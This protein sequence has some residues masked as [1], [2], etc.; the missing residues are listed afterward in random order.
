MVL[1]AL[2][3]GAFVIALDPIADGDIFWHLAAGR[4]MVHRH[5]LLDTDTFT[6]S[7]S[8]RPWL[9]LHWLFQLGSFA[10][11]RTAGL[12]GLVIA[13]AFLVATGSVILARAVSRSATPSKVVASAGSNGSF[14]VA[15][16]AIGLLGA[17]FLSRHLLLVRPVIVTLVMLALFL[18][19]LEASRSGTLRALRWLPVLQVLW[20]N[21]QGLAVLGPVLI[22]IYLVSAVAGARGDH[23]HDLLMSRSHRGWNW[24]WSW[25]RRW[26][27]P[28]PWPWP[29]REEGALSR[30]ALAITLGLCCLGLLANPHGLRAVGLSGTLFLRLLPRAG[31]V[32]SSQ[33]AENVPPWLLQRSAPAGIS[34]FAW[35]LGAFGACLV[36]SRERLTLSRLL[37]VMVF[38]GLALVAN[39]N[40]LLFYWI[41]TPIAA[42]AIAPRIR[43]ALGHLVG[44]L[45]LGRSL[46]GRRWIDRRSGRPDDASWTRRV[47]LVPALAVL[48]G[49]IALAGVAHSRESSIASPVP[50]HFPV[51]SS[52][53]L[54]RQGASGSIFAPDHHGGYLELNAPAMRPFIDTR[55]ILHTADEYLAYLQAVAD[56]VKFD[57]L[58]AAQDFRYV[59][60]TTMYPDRY[61]GLAQHL[62]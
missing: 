24:S 39:R 5:A 7:G 41:A 55:L 34:H 12:A 31:N 59:V 29:F 60:L 6:S 56:P 16:C 20:V 47:E 43:S 2:F 27:W 61:L 11:N 1:A 3:L 62:A 17:L 18:A 45:L 26:R 58:A 51:E 33:I 48:L 23:R 25:G 15:C 46:L 14:E 57:A 35:Y 50:F 53:Y 54:V 19:A 13:K 4:E 36:L 28:W 40:V 38:A 21:C 22:G 42:D 10:V 37:I 8:G 52:R 44:P 30:R 9:D 49:Q 32:F